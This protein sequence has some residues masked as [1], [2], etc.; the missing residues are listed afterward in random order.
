VAVASIALTLTSGTNASPKSNDPPR[1]VKWHMIGNIGLGMTET[2]VEYGYGYATKRYSDT[3][4]DFRLYRGS[5]LIGVSY[6]RAKHVV[7]VS[8]DSSVY[9]SPTASV[10]APRSRSVDVIA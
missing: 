3:G 8:T 4:L 6:D 7:W 2:R 10:S 1:L 9:R 5:G